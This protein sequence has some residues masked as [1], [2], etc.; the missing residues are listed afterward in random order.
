MTPIEEKF[1][2]TLVVGSCL[3]GPI[4]IERKLLDLNAFS[5]VL[6]RSGR[7]LRDRIVIGILGWF[8]VVQSSGPAQNLHELNVP[9]G[10]YS[11]W[12]EMHLKLL[13]FSSLIPKLKCILVIF[14]SHSRDIG[15]VYLL[16]EA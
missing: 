14:P 8:F 6:M 2:D 13:V 11:I 4:Q 3:F 1:V 5:V 15:V 12:I 9:F 16:C 10:H 7:I